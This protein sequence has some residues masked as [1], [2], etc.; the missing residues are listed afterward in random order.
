MSWFGNNPSVVTGSSNNFSGS[1]QETSC[2]MADMP[3]TGG[4]YLSAA[5]FC[6]RVLRENDGV[7]SVIRMVDKWTINGN[8]EAMPPTII[9]AFLVVLF[10]S[11]IHRGTGQVAVTP[12]SPSNMRMQPISM[13]IVFGGDDD[14][15]SGIVIPLGFPVQEDGPYWFEV[16]L[17]GQGLPPQVLTCIPMRVVYLRIGSMQHFPPPNQANQG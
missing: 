12:I 6:E 16:S 8:T 2:I 3:I 14:A 11:G 17:S 4:P 1:A 7:L 13:P 15:G 5:F 9:Q 10:K